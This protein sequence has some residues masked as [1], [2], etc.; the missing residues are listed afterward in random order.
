MEEELQRT[1]IVC[2]VHW[3]EAFSSVSVDVRGTA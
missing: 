2:V 1:T 3:G